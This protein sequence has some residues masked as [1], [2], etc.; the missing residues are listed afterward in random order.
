MA[1]PSRRPSQ[2][3]PPSITAVNRMEPSPPLTNWFIVPDPADYPPPARK[4]TET[5]A[6][7]HARGILAMIVAVFVG[8]LLILGMASVLGALGGVW[9]ES[10]FVILAL[11]IVVAGVVR[12][13]RR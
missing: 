1:R 5:L 8:L 11:G 6:F 7:E 10:L 12:F 9:V 3:R 13:T 2:M 4:N